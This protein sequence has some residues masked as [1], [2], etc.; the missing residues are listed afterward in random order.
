M[1]NSWYFV[2]AFWQKTLFSNV[3]VCSICNML[4]LSNLNKR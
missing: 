2:K 1:F 3:E 4:K